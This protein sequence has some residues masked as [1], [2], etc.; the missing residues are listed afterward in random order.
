M[1][2]SGGEEGAQ[3]A[4]RSSSSNYHGNTSSFSSFEQSVGFPMTQLWDDQYVD[5]GIASSLHSQG[6]PMFSPGFSDLD[7]SQPADRDLFNNNVDG[8][9]DPLL[10]Q[11]FLTQLQIS[12]GLLAPTN[13]TD[14]DNHSRTGPLDASNPPP[15][16][17]FLNQQQVNNNNNSNNAN[18]NLMDFSGMSQFSTSDI[19]S[20]LTSSTQPLSQNCM[21][22]NPFTSS[23]SPSVSSSKQVQGSEQYLMSTPQSQAGN[24]PFSSAELFQ[25]VSPILSQGSSTS[26]Q[27]D[28]SSS[29]F[30][31]IDALLKQDKA[32]QVCDPSA[33]GICSLKVC[34]GCKWNRH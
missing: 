34:S 28:S 8:L 1:W 12:G 6:D 11:K 15:P 14:I 31:T 16:S 32:F 23:L 4:S 10:L 21:S 2:S 17:H 29:Q 24:L 5:S 26:N 25:Q 27:H 18:N 33:G 22:P 7:P 30:Q 19:L 9:D 13:K 20:A 3:G